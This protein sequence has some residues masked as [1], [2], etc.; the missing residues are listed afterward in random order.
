MVNGERRGDV[1]L[2]V[3]LQ[4]EVLPLCSL[5]SETSGDGS[6]SSDQRP[7]VFNETCDV[8]SP[9]CVTSVRHLPV[10]MPFLK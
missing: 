10:E 1:D 2:A 8:W 5:Q 4:I 3:A 7:T 9:F 6:V